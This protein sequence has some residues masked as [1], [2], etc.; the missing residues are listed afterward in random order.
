VIVGS[1]LR[2]LHAVFLLLLFFGFPF[3]RRVEDLMEARL[4]LFSVSAL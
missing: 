2:I 3:F 4:C 1:L